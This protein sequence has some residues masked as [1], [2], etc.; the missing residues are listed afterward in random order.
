MNFPANVFNTTAFYRCWI[1]SPR[2]SLVFIQP[3]VNC[4]QFISQLNP[5]RLNSRSWIWQAYVMCHRNLLTREIGLRLRELG[6]APSCFSKIYI[7]ISGNILVTIK[8]VTISFN[9]LE[10]LIF[11]N[12]S[13]KLYSY[14]KIKFKYIHMPN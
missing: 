5:N 2:V 13:Y 9:K 8:P 6:W 7:L 12:V 4:H 14:N 10:P 1:K 11:I 3:T